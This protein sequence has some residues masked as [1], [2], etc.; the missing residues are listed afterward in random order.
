MKFLDLRVAWRQLVAEPL[1]AVVLI[2]GLGLAL[3]ACYLLAVLLGERY[4]PD[5][6]LHQPERIVLIDFHGN[7]PGREEDWF[8]GSPFV[9][10]PALTQARAPLELISRVAD[11]T[12]TLKQGDRITRANAIAADANLVKLFNLRS[13]QGDLQASLSRPDSIAITEGLAR[14]LFGST[15][16]LGKTLSLGKFTLTVGALLPEPGSLSQFRAEAYLGFDSPAAGIDQESREA[17]FMIA[18]QVYARLLPG[19]STAQVGAVAQALL[20]ASPVMKELPPDW[21][22]NGRKAAYMRALPVTEM[23]FEGR[24]GKLRVQVLVALA[25]AALLLLLLALL[26]FINLSSVRTLQRQ[27]EIAVRKSLGLSPTRLL[28]QF[29]VE[30]QLSIMLA[31]LVGLL[32]AWLFV[33][34]M[35]AALRVPLPDTLLQ[36]LPLLGL[37]GASLLLGLLVCLYPAWLAWRQNAAAALQGRQASEGRGG[38]W[39]RRGLSTLQFG[40]ALLACGLA[41]LLSLQNEHVLQRKI[42]YEPAGALALRTPV[43]ASATQAEDLRQA[44]RQLP[45]VTEMAWTDSVLGSDRMDRNVEFRHRDHKADLRYTAVDKDFFS[46]FKVTPLAGAIDATIRDAVVLDEAGSRAL[47]FASP[48]SALG[49]SLD[50][51]LVGINQQPQQFT[52]VAVVPTLTLEGTREPA[53]PHM[54]Q[55]Q[56]SEQALAARRGFWVLNLRLKPGTDA[57]RLLAPVW[58]RIYPDEPFSFE[59]VEEAML[60]PYAND[61]RIAQLVSATGLLALALAGFGVYALS[62]HLVQRHARE[63]VLR[64][65]HGA[66]SLQALARLAR[67]FGWLLLAGALLGLPLCFWL[68]EWYLGQFVDRAPVGLWPEALALGGLLLVSLLASLRHGLVAMGMRPIQAL[69]D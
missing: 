61:R 58:R 63:L 25:G 64:K 23:R 15:A 38:R 32:L 2:G 34:W 22:A 18:G 9:F 28:M 33:P 42:G 44:L 4:R 46:F 68:G 11:D 10:A 67:E 19:A 59:R 66:S 62:A 7:M 65:L 8:L 55:L 27:R 30:T 54:L 51:K 26:N 56:T 47:G 69:R 6:A 36:P 21:T 53:R 13:L 16:V 52:V 24:E 49:V 43:G 17:W 57:E 50:S 29:V 45:E 60:Q 31:A 20:D 14:K 5:P 1:N 40:I 3:A 41:L 12:F 48:A 39:L 35:S 37:M